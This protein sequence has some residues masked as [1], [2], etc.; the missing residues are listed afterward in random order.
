MAKVKSVYT[1]NECGASSPKWVGQ[2]PSCNAWN[3]L[4]ET[5][6]VPAAHARAGR[7]YGAPAAV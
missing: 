3:T 4:Y 1:C 7:Q 6:V 2:C 5:T